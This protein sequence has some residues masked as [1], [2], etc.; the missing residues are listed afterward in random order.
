[1]AR[2]VD[3]KQVSKVPEWYAETLFIVL[4]LASFKCTAVVVSVFGEYY[5]EVFRSALRA[6]K[7]RLKTTVVVI[8]DS[9]RMPRRR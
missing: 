1:M 9:Y 3:G 5:Y 6:A 7:D 4:S 2:S 8:V